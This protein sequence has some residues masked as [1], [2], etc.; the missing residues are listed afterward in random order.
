MCCRVQDVWGYS[1]EYNQWFDLKPLGR[2]PSARVYDTINFARDT[3]LNGGSGVI[4]GYVIGGTFG[5]FKVDVMKYNC[6]TNRFSSLYAEVCSRFV[7]RD[8]DVAAAGSEAISTLILCNN[9]V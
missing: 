6:I 2:V 4:T 7:S 1:R 5:G 3:K 8:T 9:V